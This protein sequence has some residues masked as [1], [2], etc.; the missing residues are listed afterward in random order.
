ME[1]FLNFKLFVHKSLRNIAYLGTWDNASTKGTFLCNCFNKSK[2]LLNCSSM[3]SL[4]NL[5]GYG[6]RGTYSFTGVDVV[7]SIIG[8]AS[9][10]FSRLSGTSIYCSFTF[11]IILS[12]SIPTSLTSLRVIA[13][14]CSRGLLRYYSV[15][16]FVVSWIIV[17][18]Y[19]NLILQVLKRSLM[20]PHRRYYAVESGVGLLKLGVCV[21]YE[22]NTSS[23]KGFRSD[24]G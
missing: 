2:N 6:S 18:Q 5:E 3:R 9:L 17:L 4:F 7:F 19:A 23:S 14:R 15:S 8:M 24:R 1:T 20:V 11:S 13:L 22:Q 10:S 12:L 16:C 21:L